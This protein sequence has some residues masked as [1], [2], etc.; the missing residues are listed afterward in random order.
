MPAVLLVSLGPVQDFIASARRCG[1]LWYGSWLLSDLAK[2]TALGIVDALGGSEV[3]ETLVF[4]GAASR[5]SLSPGSSTAVANKLLA[6]VPDATAAG[7]VAEA[8]RTA[9]VQRLD[10]LARAAF[11][12]IGRGDRNRADHFL[13]ARAWEQVRDLVEYVWVSVEF[14]GDGYAVARREAE[15][16]LDARKRTKIW[17][18]PSWSD[19]VPKSTLDGARESVLHE[20]LFAGADRDPARAEWLRREYGV[21][22]SERLC[23]VGLLKR[24]GVHE[25]PGGKSERARFFSTPHL[26]ALPLMTRLAEARDPF[27]RYALVLRNAFGAAADEVLGAAARQLGVFGRADGQ[28]FFRSRLAEIAEESGEPLACTTGLVAAER[29]LA[30]YFSETGTS[31]PPPY[32][33]VLLADGDHMGRAIDS[34]TTFE[35]HRALSIA[36]AAFAEAARTIVEA[37]DGS[38]VYSGGDD[39]LALLPL[40]AAL[41][42]GSE[43]RE[44][45]AAKLGFIGSPAA[46]A[47]TLSVGLGVAHFI[48]P[49]STA[50]DLARRAERLAKRTRNALGVIVDKRGGASTEVHGSWLPEASTPSLLDRL[51]T[52]I[53]LVRGDE[54]P[55]KAGFEL[56]AVGS[57]LAGCSSDL[58]SAEARRILR[59]KRPAHGSAPAIAREHLEKLELWGAA[60]PAKLADE[61]IVAR[62]FAHARDVALG[63]SSNVPRAAVHP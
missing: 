19:V 56:R 61:L 26:A 23:G 14:A 1:D 15:R 35:E 34:A 16:I 13:E 8:G 24:A 53:E 31:E 5:A 58:L 52:M 6:R 18:Q 28:I 44:E 25:D 57:A 36:L 9:M 51:E 39:V 60:S 2:A 21:H 4:P 47:P 43:L 49:M 50:L 12:G 54:V 29:G 17:A 63:P 62:L 32:Y 40:H 3:A 42:C 45:F 20:R 38:L 30:S 41:A 37:H 11:D 22:A 48:E 59:R 10:S 46:G 55:D 27:R 33:A 7:G